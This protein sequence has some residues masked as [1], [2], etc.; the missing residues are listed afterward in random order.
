M[1]DSF[2]ITHPEGGAESRSDLQQST[3]SPEVMPCPTDTASPAPTE[4]TS[5]DA[6]HA[7]SKKPSP[8]LLTTL[9]SLAV[10]VTIAIFVITF[11]VQAFQIPSESMENTLLIGDF[12]LVDKV[13]YGPPGMWNLLLPYKRIKRGDIVVF[14]WP[15]HPEQ[16][17]VK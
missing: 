8:G 5:A 14:R 7:E 13:Q 9:Q 15:V 3:V 10:T 11:L 2:P 17:F 4:S 1:M 12:L 16:H 6:T